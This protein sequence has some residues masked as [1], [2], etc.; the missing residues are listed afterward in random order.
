MSLLESLP[1]IKQFWLKYW[2]G[3]KKEQR[4]LKIT[5]NFAEHDFEVF[6]RRLFLNETNIFDTYYQANADIIN[7]FDIDIKKVCRSVLI[8]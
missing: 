2:G 6:F 7:K 8:S 3:H 5:T 4:L 1:A